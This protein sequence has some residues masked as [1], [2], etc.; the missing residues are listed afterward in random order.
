VLSYLFLLLAFGEENSPVRPHREI[1][2]MPLILPDHRRLKS[3][4]RQEFPVVFPLSREWNPET[5]SLQHKSFRYQAAMASLSIPMTRNEM[6]SV[7]I[8]LAGTPRSKSNAY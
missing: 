1:R 2:R 7:A 3:A 6:I 8:I 5:G 4:E